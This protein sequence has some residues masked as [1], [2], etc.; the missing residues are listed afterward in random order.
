MWYKEYGWKFN[1]FTIKPS[2]DIIGYDA[3]REKL[4]N[5]I[6]SG[7]I[8]FL[9]GNPGAGKTSLLKW[10]ENNIR[11]HFPVYLNMETIDKNFSIQKFLYDHT[12]FSR[13]LLGLEFPKNT[14]FL[15]DESAVTNEEFR[16]ALKLHFDENR[17]KSIVFAQAGEEA[18]IPE[19]F[20][21]RVGHRIVKLTSLKEEVAFDFIKKRCGKFCPFTEGAIT[22]IAEKSNYLPRKILENCENIC[23]NM[24]GKKEINI[25]DVQYVLRIRPE[26]ETKTD[27]LSPME[28]N[29][30]KILKQ[31]NKTSQELA[32]LLSTTEG[33][34]GKQLSKLMQKNLVKIISHKRPKI[35]SSS[36]I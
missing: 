33:S 32:E 22:F 1:P 23:I 3:E 36:K 21:N 27:S 17:I 11:K 6:S 5:F 4:V 16:H 14:V 29:I 7:D 35:Y 9:I 19:S 13:R 24:K 2:P 20:R 10:V 8:C 26:E 25:N 15:L 18:D 34:V 30:L 12:K 28:E 31:T